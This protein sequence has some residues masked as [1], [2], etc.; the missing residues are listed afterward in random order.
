MFEDSDPQQSVWLETE[1]EWSVRY[2]GITR[3]ASR[4]FGDTEAFTESFDLV[5]PGVLAIT[6][7]GTWSVSLQG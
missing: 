4:T 1:G 2:F 6:T 3:E 7:A 5:R